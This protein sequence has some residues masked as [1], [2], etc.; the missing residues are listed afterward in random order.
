MSKLQNTELL[1]GKIDTKLL[2]GCSVCR[3]YLA[4]IESIRRSDGNVLQLHTCNECNHKWKEF[5]LQL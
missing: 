2:Y 5:W 3:S 1:I 4:T